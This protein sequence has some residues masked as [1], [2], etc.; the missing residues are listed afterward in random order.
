MDGKVHATLVQ[1]VPL[2]GADSVH[3]QGFT[4]AGVKVAVLDTGIDTNH[5]DLQDDLAAQHCFC[6]NHPSPVFA[7]CPGGGSE[8]ANA[9]DDE[10]HGTSVAGIITSAGVAAPLGAAPDAEIVA[11]KVL[12][13]TGNGSFSDIAAALDWVL[14]ESGTPG[15]PVQGVRVVNMSLSDSGQYNNAS[16]SPCAGTNTAIL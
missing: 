1:G 13:S 6:D 14:T 9:E 4:G 10:G 11:V 16:A 5:P 15:S 8:E 2:V 7:C 12:D 3:A